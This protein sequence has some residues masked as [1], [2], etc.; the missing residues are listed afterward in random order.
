MMHHLNLHPL[1]EYIP[2]EELLE[3]KDPVL[4]AAMTSTEEGM[5]V[6]RNKGS[7]WAGCFRRIED[8]L[9]KQAS[10]VAFEEKPKVPVKVIR[11]S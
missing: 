4:L 8:P 10:Q 3:A 9:E 7:K 6:E 1:F 2:T 5:K 11:R